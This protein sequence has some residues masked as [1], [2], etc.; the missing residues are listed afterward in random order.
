MEEIGSVAMLA[1]KRSVGVAPD[2]GECVTCMP[3]PSVNKTAHSGFE[4][5]IS[6]ASQ[7]GL[8]S[9]KT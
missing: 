4:T 2:L 3:P 1:G 5:G 8:V 9:S 7:E 6:V